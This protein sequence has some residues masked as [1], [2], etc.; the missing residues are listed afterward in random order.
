MKSKLTFQSR[1]IDARLASKALDQEVADLKSRKTIIEV[2]EKSQ[3]KVYLPFSETM[4]LN[5]L[6]AYGAH[7]DEIALFSPLK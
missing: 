6:D 4:L 2:S 5:G 7:A 3:S 1:S